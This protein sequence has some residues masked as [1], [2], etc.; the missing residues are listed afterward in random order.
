MRRA[1]ALNPKEK[2]L[3][4]YMG[5]MLQNKDSVLA[6][7]PYLLEEKK[8]SD[9]VLCDFLLARVD[10][11]K[12]DYPASINYLESY[13]QR[14]KYNKMAHSNLMLLYIQTQ[15]R[16]KAIA[17]AKLMRNEGIEVP[18]QFLQQLGIR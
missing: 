7:E 3:N 1:Y 18:T 16:D 4:F 10:M 8:I 6:S 13:L 15:Q 14:D 11:E 5:Q 12:K 17:H 2:Y 9:Y